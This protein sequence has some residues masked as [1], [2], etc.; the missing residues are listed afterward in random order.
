MSVMQR[1]NTTASIQAPGARVGDAHGGVTTA[2]AQTLTA[3]YSF[4]KFG[5]TPFDRQQIITAHGLDDDATVYKATGAYNAGIQVGNLLI[6]SDAEWY[7]ILGA[8]PQR[9]R[10][11]TPH[12]VAFVIVRN[13]GAV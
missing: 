4:N 2:A 6:V 13:K 11:P 5:V 8:K 12:H 1:C 3:S 9:G 7:R 10:V